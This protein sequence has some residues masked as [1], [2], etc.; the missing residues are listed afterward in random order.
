MDN[1][2]SGLVPAQKAPKFVVLNF[3]EDYVTRKG[4]AHGPVVFLNT[5]HVD[6]ANPR[7]EHEDANAAIAAAKASDMLKGTKVYVN[8]SYVTLAQASKLDIQ[9][10]VYKRAGL[11]AGWKVQWWTEEG[12]DEYNFARS[13]RTKAAA[14]PAPKKAKRKNAKLY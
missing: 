5:Y 12:A 9:P 8:G 4:E 7:I 11:D 1:Q 14:K 6:K 10:Y 3:H 2:L 13:K